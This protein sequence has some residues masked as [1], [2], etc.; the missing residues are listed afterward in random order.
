[1]QKLGNPVPFFFDGSGRP[2]TGGYVYVGVANADPQTNPIDLFWD[3]EGDDPAAQPLRT[4]GGFLVNGT[5]PASV[6]FD[7]DD[8][9]MRVRD[10]NGVEVFYSPSVY[11]PTDAFQPASD[12]LT[13]IAAL[14][15]TAF[16]RNLLTLANSTALATATGIPTPLP[17]AGGT[18]T[19]NITR[20]GA[21]VH[22][23]HTDSALT[24]GRIFLTANGAA[25]PTSL[26]GDIW[27]EKS[28]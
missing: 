14:T 11:G 19:G 7:E 8:Y 27:L 18:I 22:T 15:T 3:L 21:G 16:G 6:F 10:D 4:I 9:S 5:Q 26:P 1:M 2:L 24:S 23:Y 20:Q 25:D 28:A 17:A 12:T 13:A